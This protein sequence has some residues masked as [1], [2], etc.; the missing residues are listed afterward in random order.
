MLQKQVYLFLLVQL[1]KLCPSVPVAA[2]FD[3]EGWEV[4]IVAG[5]PVVLLCPS[6]AGDIEQCLELLVPHGF[7]ATTPGFFIVVRAIN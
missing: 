3:A 7:Y 6:T 1:L 4:V 5:I 2:G